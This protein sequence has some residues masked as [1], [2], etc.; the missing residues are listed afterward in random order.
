MVLGPF[1]WF[2]KGTPEVVLLKDYE[3]YQHF[4]LLIGLVSLF[5]GEWLINGIRAIE[6]SWVWSTESWS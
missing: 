3:V 5:G 6:G 2:R 4:G 1:S